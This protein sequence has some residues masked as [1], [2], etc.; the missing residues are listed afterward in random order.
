MH[1]KSS[2]NAL[3]MPPYNTL[4]DLM[5]NCNHTYNTLY[6]LSTHCYSFSKYNALKKHMTNKPSN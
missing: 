6:Y 2:F 4:Y 3:I 5:N 1:Y